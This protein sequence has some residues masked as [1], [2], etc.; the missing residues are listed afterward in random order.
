VVYYS[1][2]LILALLIVLICTRDM[3][4]LAVVP[5]TGKIYGIPVLL[6]MLLKWPVFFQMDYMNRF[7]D[8]LKPD[9]GVA[10]IVDEPR[11]L[12]MIKDQPDLS[13]Y[14]PFAKENNKLVVV[15]NPTL[16][17]AEDHPRIGGAL[18]LYPVYAA[19]VQAIYKDFDTEKQLIT[20]VM[21]GTSPETFLQ[22]IHN[23]ADMVFMLE[24]SEQQY[25][26]AKQAGVPLHLTKTGREAF[27]FFVN[28]GNPVDGL[29]SKQIRDIYTRKTINWR[30]LGGRDQKIMPFQRPEGSG[31]QTAMIRMMQGQTLT[32]P[33]HEESQEFMGGI[34]NRVA[35]YRNYDN[36][37]GYS[38]RFFVENM[39]QTDGVKLLAVDG[40]AP[41]VGNIRNG[42]YPFTGDFYIITN[43]PPNEKTQKLIDWF[44]SPQGQRLIEQTGYVPVME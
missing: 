25:A 30:D 28:S 32:R 6:V 37:I 9:H 36:S 10:Q 8:V 27:V 29:S 21:T 14:Q 19:A 35:D 38:F 20:H 42:S 4:R 7:G 1:L 43:G 41:T 39:F 15:D 5:S 24:P 17:I 22:L 33:I 2:Q 44:L 12:G 26:A 13:P 16:T 34:I 11:C 40:V 3:K 31:S 23:R 18:A